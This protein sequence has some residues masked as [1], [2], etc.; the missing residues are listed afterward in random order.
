MYLIQSKI[1]TIIRY[2]EAA[3]LSFW[4]LL[5]VKIDGPFARAHDKGVVIKHKQLGWYTKGNGKVRKPD[6]YIDDL[7]ESRTPS[8]GKKYDKRAQSPFEAEYYI[9]K[10]TL[11]NETILD[12]MMGFATAGIAA[13]QLKR[14]FIGI[15]IN[16]KNF[17]AA[18]TNIVRSEN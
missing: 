14:N 4:R 5:A 2:M 11:P 12:P 7:I 8:E 10:L 6:P 17:E 16:S 1:P 13:L 3:G 15:E 18:K 9:S